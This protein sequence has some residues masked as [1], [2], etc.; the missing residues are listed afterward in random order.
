[1]KLL[2]RHGLQRELA[3][4]RSCLHLWRGAEGLPSWVP[5]SGPVARA[6]GLPGSSIQ[7]FK[8]EVS[9]PLCSPPTSDTRHSRLCVLEATV[10]LSNGHS[11]EGLLY[12]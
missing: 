9:L 1:M 10:T 4:N 11:V 12:P 6:T 7:S 8:R 2:K 5:T 3:E